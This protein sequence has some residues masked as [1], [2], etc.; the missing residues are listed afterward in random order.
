MPSKTSK[1]KPKKKRKVKSALSKKYNL[2]GYSPYD[3]KYLDDYYYD[4]DDANLYASFF[5]ECLVHLKGDEAGQPFILS[6]W[7]DFIIRNMF[8]WKRKSDGKRRYKEVFCGIPR[9]NGKSTLAGGVAIELLVIDNEPGAEVYCTAAAKDQAQVVFKPIRQLIEAQPTLMH[10]VRLYKSSIVRIDDNSFLQAIACDAATKHG[11]N[12]H[13]TIFDE[14]HAHAKRG[15]V[16]TMNSAGGTRSQAM[17]FYI[18]T[19]D[20][21]REDS[22]CNEKWD[23]ARQVRDGIID[24]PYHLPVLFEPKN[25][26][27]WER[28]TCWMEVNPELKKAKKM[29]YMQREYRKAKLS[30]A[31][32]NVFKRLQLNIRTGQENRLIPMDEWENCGKLKA[33]EPK[34]PCYV[35]LDL[36]QIR[37][38]TALA[39]YWPEAGHLVKWFF[40]CPTKHTEASGAGVYV[41]WI[42]Q[43]FIETT[44]GNMTDYKYIVAR[45]VELCE[46]YSIQDIAY[47]PWNASQVAVMLQDDH[48]IPCI[49]YRQGFISMNEPT[50]KLL[51]LIGEG[52]LCHDN[53]PVAWWMADNAVGKTDPSGNIKFNKE[54]ETKKIDGLVA[55]AMAMGRYIVQSKPKV[56]VYAKGG[57]GFGWVEEDQDQ[58][59]QD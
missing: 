55:L 31:Y 50:K 15:F 3:T 58:E 21:A 25:P 48:G 18:T 26:D 52:K 8:G 2:A 29:E 23:Y 22:I 38:L 42:D 30:P 34:G 41:P 6:P 35:G 44:P 14:L 54:K 40:W 51:T 59:D 4:E 47:D 27:H 57:R 28:E 33:Q 45:V 24:D 56:S 10:Q 17:D 12:P 11:L 20:W 32:E 13:G 1:K 49:E 19:S 53:N 9:K 43:G 39:L 7:E 46:K 36:A 37:D 5:P 16:D